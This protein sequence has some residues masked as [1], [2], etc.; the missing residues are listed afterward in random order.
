[1]PFVIN[2]NP[3]AQAVQNNLGKAHGSQANAMRRLSSGLRINSAK[4]DPAGLAKSNRIETTI[5]SQ[6]QID[7]NIQQGLS[8]ASVGETALNE[9]QNLLQRGQE[10][11]V[12]AANGTLSDSD[13]GSLNQEFACLKEQIS[14]IANTTEIFGNHPLLAAQDE[15]PPSIRDLF[16][17]SGTTKFWSSGLV[18]MSRIPAGSSNVTFRLDAFTADDDI[19]VFTKDGTHL[20]GT[21]L[22]DNVWTSKGIT[23]PAA[24]E[25]SVFLT[26][27]GYAEGATYDAGVLNSGGPTYEDPPTH[28]TT[29]NGMT[30]TYSGDA[31]R[32]DPADG[33]NDGLVWSN[34]FEELHV[35]QVTEDLLVS[36]V[37]SGA[38]EATATWDYIPAAGTEEPES[39]NIL[40]ET[41]PTGEQ[42]YIGIDKTPSDI[43]ALGLSDTVIDPFEEAQK[44]I[45]DIKAA[46]A[47]I[48]ANRAYYG[49]K[50]SALEQKAQ[51]TQKQTVI[52]S[53]ARSRI[54][55]A[56]MAEETSHLTRSSIVQNAA[57]AILT[58]ANS[59]PGISL[60]LL[61]T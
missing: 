53:E 22:G 33:N 41:A 14:H 28:A 34:P 10:L 23:S 46:V 59:L 18:P 20:V 37:G 21:D 30:L 61:K 44:A 17:T 27:N 29:Y 16:E 42:A 60:E 43:A 51:L 50:M 36:V 39:V 49:A 38:F 55:D 48:S 54:I 25:S 24:L 45:D 52:N 57:S 4:D 32:T 5:R 11:A 19:Q 15:G 2:T 7:Q 1:M 13:R 47:K 3:L 56:D 40:V 26:E 8:Y 12:Q 31:D 6:G 9:I 35:D 58:Q